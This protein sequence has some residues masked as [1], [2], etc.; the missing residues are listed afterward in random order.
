M[1]TAPKHPSTRARRNRSTTAAVL[2]A[3]ADAKP[4]AL[5]DRDDGWHPQTVA[6]WTD[7]WASPMAGEFLASDVHGLLMVAALVDDYW[8]KPTPA[9]LAEIRLQGQAYGCRRWTAADCNGPSSA[10]KPRRTAG[11][12]GGPSPPETRD[13][14]CWTLRA[15]RR[16]SL[17]HSPRRA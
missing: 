8:R 9:K 3:A 7:L 13:W 10:P 12:G 17:R 11:S 1:P 5:P 15:R 16:Q 4:P 2:Q 14:C 6:W